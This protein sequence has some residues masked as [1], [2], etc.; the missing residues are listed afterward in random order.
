GDFSGYAI[1]Q[2]AKKKIKKAY[3][4]GFI[5]KFSK[6]A[7]GVKQTHVKGSK[8]DM[9]FLAKIAQKYNADKNTIEKIKN[10]NTARHVLEIVSE[11]KLE[12]FFDGVC[13]EVYKHLRDQ[14][15]MKVEI[16]AI[17]FDFDGNVIGRHSQ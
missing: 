17:M 4:I 9:N 1:E 13:S 3:V 5:G 7:T 8:V 15:E 14:S 10:A 12:K 6:I 11:N 16:D 2:C